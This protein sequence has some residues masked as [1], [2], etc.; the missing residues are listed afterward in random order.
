[1]R[2]PAA[3]KAMCRQTPAVD[4][5]DRCA[6]PNASFTYLPTGEREERGWA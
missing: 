6:V 1:M 2:Y 4:A 5:C 3:L